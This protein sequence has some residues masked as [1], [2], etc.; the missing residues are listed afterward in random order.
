MLTWKHVRETSC[1]NFSVFLVQKAINS[2]T[3]LLWSQ[4]N[5]SKITYETVPKP[6]YN[7]CNPF[8]NQNSE[9]QK[10]QILRKINFRDIWD[11]FFSQKFRERN[12]FILKKSLELIWRIFFLWEKFSFFHI[13]SVYY[14]QCGNCKN[15]LSHFFAKISWK[16]WF[17]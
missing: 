15:S 16:Q 11:I 13:V 8:R 1:C 2:F 4:K 12:G 5:F 14:T 9:T 7:L 10:S 6:G 3:S 17:Y